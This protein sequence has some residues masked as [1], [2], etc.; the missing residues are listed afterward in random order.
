MTGYS[1]ALEIGEAVERDVFDELV[2]GA[3]VGIQSVK[4]PGT[5]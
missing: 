3:G 5:P 2:V 1:A 4:A